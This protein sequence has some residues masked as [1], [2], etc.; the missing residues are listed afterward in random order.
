MTPT[1]PGHDTPT[2]RT[3]GDDAPTGQTDANDVP[4]GRDDPSDATEFDTLLAEPPADTGEAGSTSRVSGWRRVF[5]GNRTLWIVASVAVLSL[6]AGLLIGR[7]VVSPADAAA[8]AQAPEAGLITVPVELGE[9]SNDVTI[10]GDVGYAD[11]VEVTIDAADIGGAAVVTGQVPAAGAVFGPLAIALEVVGRPVIVLPGELPAY[12]T[13]RVGVSGPDVL[14]FKQAMAAVG[15]N[16]GDVDSNVF[17]AAAA[18]AVGA[19][20]DAVGYPAPAP[21]E[22]SADAVRAAEEGVRSADQAIQAARAELNRA[23]GGASPVE[24][25]EA[26][27]AISSAKRQL[28]TAQAQVPP[29]PDQIADLQDALGLAILRREQLSLPPDTSGQQAALD[30]A[31]A[32]R[33]AAVAGLEKAREEG[34]SYLPASEVLYLTQLPRRVDNVTVA[35]GDVLSGAAM[36]VSGADV[37]VSASAAEADAS[38]LAVGAEA[39]FELPD[40]TPHRAVVAKIEPPG[41]SSGEGGAAPSSRWSLTLQPDPLTPEQIS[42]LQG[43]NV[44]VTI[45]VGST[46]GEVLSVPLA[47]LTAGPGGESRVEVVVGD[48]KDGKGAE[49]RLVVV[50]TGLAAAGYVEVAALDDELAQGDLVVVG[51]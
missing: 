26:D 31:R 40:G 6:V 42:A 50:E 36:T 47:A 46:Q 5:R 43:Q 39:S 1:A 45:P 44:R 38:L 35:R 30:S 20:Y 16:A 29:D 18:G 41:A 28:A 14:Q 3:P 37:Q 17:D 11:A 2:G 13:L 24:L 34:L 19:L 32:Q 27:N 21:A 15:I 7:F 9:L 10:R 25:R 51:Q 33:D 49:T 23:G 12:R 4:T 8:N 48:P 22:G